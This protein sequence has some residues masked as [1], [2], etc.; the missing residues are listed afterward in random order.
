[1][2]NTHHHSTLSDKES[3]LLSASCVELGQLDTF[4]LGAE[5][6]RQILDGGIGQEASGLR[7]VECLESRVDVLKV[8]ERLELE[9]GI[10]SREI[11]LVRVGPAR[12]LGFVQLGPPAKFG[13]RSAPTS[14][15]SGITGLF[16]VLGPERQGG[17]GTS[18]SFCSG[19]GGSHGCV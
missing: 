2:A 8:G 14:D 3:K 11:S 17:Q 18:D 19:S 13:G 10:E 7:V 15:R 9:R 16:S 1:M 6:R 12:L 4:D 5:V